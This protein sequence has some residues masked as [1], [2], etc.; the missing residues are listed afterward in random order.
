MAIKVVLLDIEGTVCPISF[1]KDV[2]F[3][4][5]L[6]ALPTALT[7]GWESPQFLPYRNAF[8]P[9]YSSSP[10]A[11]EAHVRDLMAQ[12]LKISYLKS[13]QGYLWQEGYRRGEIKAPLFED[14]AKAVQTWA[15]RGH[16]VMIYSSGSVPA[17]K[18]LFGHTDGQPSDLTGYIAGWF[19]TVNA[20]P[21][22]DAGSYAKIAATYPEFGVPANWLFLSDNIRE[23]AAAKEAGMQS[24]AVVRPG[25]PELSSEDK[26]CHGFIQ[27]F[28]EVESLLSEE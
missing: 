15:L 11:M 21:K 2:L 4:Y 7:T 12:D 24:F 16:R 25:N 26:E 10:S 23:V 19:D 14:V 8:P 22:T 6:R 1:V 13:L 27:S 5:A 18:L 20:G 28:E 3:P 9:E 17:Q